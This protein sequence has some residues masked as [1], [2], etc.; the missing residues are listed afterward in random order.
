MKDFYKLVYSELTGDTELKNLL[1]YSNTNKNI[2]RFEGL[3]TY[4]WDRAL[5]FGKLLTFPMNLDPRLSH[6]VLRGE[7]QI[8]A[9]DRNDREKVL[10]VRKR[11]IEVLQNKSL[12][13]SNLIID[14]LEFQ[15][16]VPVGYIDDLHHY[17]GT[18]FFDIIIK[19]LT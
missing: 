9:I 17:V 11:A 16:N 6:K 3:E 15:R 8:Q 4:E 18:G 13:N 12:K 1:G 10:D 14:R 7:F 19:D 2:R 5:F